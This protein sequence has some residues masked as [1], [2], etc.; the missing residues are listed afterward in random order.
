MNVT[1]L[2]IERCVNMSFSFDFNRYNKRNPRDYAEFQDDDFD[3]EFSDD[4]DFDFDD[5][6]DSED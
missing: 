3:Y 2:N 1:V 5:E 6:F 4:F